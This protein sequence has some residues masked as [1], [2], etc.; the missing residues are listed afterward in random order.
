MFLQDLAKTLSHLQKSVLPFLCKMQNKGLP[1]LARKGPYPAKQ[2][3]F[4]QENIDLTLSNQH[5]TLPKLIV[6]RFL[7]RTL[8]HNDRLAV[9][10]EFGHNHS[11]AHNL[12]NH[13]RREAAS[14]R[15]ILGD[16]EDRERMTFANHAK[17]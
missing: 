2:L 10:I 6:G 8:C 1:G 7:H 14:R 13:C 17:R 9:C 4:V 3:L 12:V 5:A 16:L 11:V 15:D